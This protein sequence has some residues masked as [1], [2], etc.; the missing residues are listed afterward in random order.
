MKFG[1]PYA[2]IICYIMRLPQQKDVNLKVLQDIWF[3]PK[4]I[5]LD[6]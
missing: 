3:I 6:R 1:L 5:P 2:I 4:F